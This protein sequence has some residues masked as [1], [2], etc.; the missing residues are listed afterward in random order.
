MALRRAL[1]LF[2]T[3]SFL[4]IGSTANAFSIEDYDTNIAKALNGEFTIL[5]TLQ[6]G[7]DFGTENTS[8][9]GLLK[10]LYKRF[11]VEGFTT[12]L[13]TKGNALDI[14]GFHIT[15]DGIRGEG[16]FGKVF[17]LSA[18]SKTSLAKSVKNIKK[19]RFDIA[20]KML[21]QAPKLKSE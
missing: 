18:E 20:V 8:L 12:F 3:F 7:G 5:S 13:S 11:G 6:T 4:L 17:A 19:V 21:K 10:A 1:A 2:L 16:G 15:S 14:P 9:N